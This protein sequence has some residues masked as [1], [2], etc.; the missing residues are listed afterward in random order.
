LEDRFEWHRTAF[1][2]AVLFLCIGLAVSWL[3]YFGSKEE[4]KLF[5]VRLFMSFVYLGI[6]FWFWV[7]HY[8]EK[9]F[10]KSRLV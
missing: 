6:G 9:L 2:T 7:S 3:V 4:V 10:K 8:P 5:A 1:Y